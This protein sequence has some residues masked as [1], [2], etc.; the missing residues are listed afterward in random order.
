MNADRDLHELF[1]V[2]DSV[3]VPA[4]RRIEADALARNDRAPRTWFRSVAVAAVAAAALIVGL[5][6]VATRHTDAVDV[7]GPPPTSNSDPT[8][9]SEAPTTRNEA[10]SR[11]LPHHAAP[12]ALDCAVA[13][14]ATD[15]SGVVPTAEPSPGDAPYPAVTVEP[16]P[17]SIDAR[18]PRLVTALNQTGSWFTLGDRA[19]GHFDPASGQADQVF[20]I[21]GSCH[22]WDG[23]QATE[24][25][26]AVAVC[27]GELGAPDPG[28]CAVVVTALGDGTTIGAWD[29]PT[30]SD[31]PSLSWSEDELFVALRGPGVW[32]AQLDPSSGAGTLLQDLE[33]CPTALPVSMVPGTALVTA[34]CNG[35][36]QE[37]VVADGRTGSVLQRASF[38]QASGAPLV[39]DGTQVWRISE[40]RRDA[41]T[42]AEIE[43][44]PFSTFD[45]G[46]LLRDRNDVFVDALETRASLWTVRCLDGCSGTTSVEIARHDP[47]GEVT[48]R[49]IATD[50]LVSRETKPSSILL[51]AADDDGAWYSAGGH[52]YRLNR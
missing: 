15:F 52:L 43:P 7:A 10:D 31:R 17:G 30:F 48:D 22:F 5:S 4:P 37:R 3:P 27:A 41:Q 33:S 42:F 25:K 2:L 9:S 16:A 19:I 38:G 1:E 34:T 21:E 6:L 51:L 39:S 45:L 11:S 24:D 40:P 44:S 13:P 47:S 8:T 20:Q 32:V 23:A 26:L 29:L 28:P 49:W 35:E 36:S 14:T 18:S 12:T 50:T 46:A